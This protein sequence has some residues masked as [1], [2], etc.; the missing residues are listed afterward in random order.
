MNFV[1]LLGRSCFSFLQGAS[2]PEEMVFRAQ[3][4]GYRG[5]ALCDLNGLHGVVRGYQAAHHPSLFSEE[6]IG[7]S[8]LSSPF[9]YHVGAEMQ[10]PDG[11]S[12]ALYP[13]NKYGYAN[14]C[15]LVT[16][17]KR[18]VEKTYSCL[19][20]ED[21]LAHSDDLIV[22]PLPPWSEPALESLT[23]AFTERIYLPVW[24]DYSWKS[25]QLYDEA[26]K[27]E[28]RFGIPW[29]A[30]QRPFMHTPHRKP[31][32]DILTCNLHSCSLNEAQTR[33]L[34]NSERHLKPLPELI[35]LW[36]ERPDALE[37]SLEISQ[38]LQFSLSELRYQY[39]HADLPQGMTSSEFLRHLTEE[40]LKIR[41]P[42][43]VSVRVR[44]LVEHELKL[45]HDL[46][47]ED[48]FLTLWDVCR[49]AREQGIL[50]QGRGSAAN[51]I[52]CYCLGLTTVDP[53]KFSLM[54]ERFISKERGEPPDIDIDFESQR[55]EEVIQYI[56]RKYGEKHAA[57]VCTVICY[58]SRMA[59]RDTAKALGLEQKA[60]D[61]MVRFMGR[62]GLSR[63]HENPDKAREW[64]LDPHRFQLL[65][66]WTQ[67]LIGFPRHLGIHTG[68]FLISQRPIL[69]SV[70]V[71]KATMEGRYV[72]Q[73]NKDD[74]NFLKMMKVD[75]LGLGMLSALKRTFDI[76]KDS[77]NLNYNLYNLPAED[78]ET[79]QMIQK[80]D[81]VGVFQIESRAQ[82]TLLPRLKPKNFY[83]LVVEV[84]IVRP[85]PLQGGMVHPYIRRRNGEEKIHYA[86]EDL[87]PILEKTFGVPIF[88]EQ[89][90]QIASTVC[91]FTPGESDEL[92]RIMSS[93]WQKHDQMQGLRKRLMNGM[94]SYGIKKEYAE[95][96]YQTIIGFAS[97]GFPESHAASFAHLTYASCYLKR[98]H[99][100]AFLCG[101]LNAQPM[102]FYS[103]RIL[104]ADA[105]RHGVQMLPLDI[106]ISD[107]DYK[108]EK[109]DSDE[110]FLSVRSGFRGLF[111]LRENL[112]QKLV[113]TRNQNG[114]F[115]GL[116]D[117]VQRANLNRSTLLKLAAAGALNS[118][119][120]SPREAM[121]EVLSIEL[122]SRSI[123]YGQAREH[124]DK[125]PVPQLP[126]ESSWES[127]KREYQSQGFS[128][129]LHPM[130]VVRET[131]NRWW[132]TQNP[133]A[134]RLYRAN[135]LDSLK[136]HHPVVV[137]GMLSLMQRPSTAKGFAF[138]TMEDETGLF[139]VILTSDVYQQYRMVLLNSP[140]MFIAG[141]LQK[142][143]GV[144]H[145]KADQLAPLNAHRFLKP[146]RQPQFQRSR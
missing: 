57:M 86:H 101:L 77:K 38:R 39:P 42:Q 44:N 63:L 21:V 109:T 122:D 139:N 53:D 22:L 30:T 18:N 55:R 80:A 2:H 133:T 40:G 98:H 82:M 108:L 142:A 93:S 25:V 143:S 145:L 60:I 31:L 115:T 126:A 52:V 45:I 138:L 8:Q 11:S 19:K 105:Q 16:L 69:E 121:W 23:Q 29:V 129:Q 50:H 24:K 43:G 127:L 107:Y 99:P 87:K 65:L 34:S 6:G 100:E 78:S 51:S 27:I 14:L 90:M 37:R 124:F 20:L 144:I 56:Y 74:L 32:M 49:F 71:E 9:S 136:S 66:K 83:D 111:G 130:G 140:L 96:I 3:E 36:R 89:I 94:L 137:A 72:V 103:P 70:P 58:R 17:S 54:F 33:L 131:L 79:Y 12:L 67:E 113:E 91:G 81:T 106:Q 10:L 125:S 110:K 114:P 41:Y 75:V 26:L 15:Q 88:Q 76:L 135:E 104:I 68:G 13:M 132:K 123:L 64:N 28:K 116:K 95:Q 92:R 48:Y 46:N 119:G 1:E 47:Y 118:L 61:Q 5:L 35:H 146:M 134:P 4:L 59:L 85:G 128:L 97:Y 102:G 73:W 84:A 120:L 7:A 117:L 112:V 141:K 62:E